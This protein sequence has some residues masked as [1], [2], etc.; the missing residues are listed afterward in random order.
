MTVCC[1]CNASRVPA[2]RPEDLAPIVYRL[3]EVTARTQCIFRPLLSVSRLIY[4]RPQ[5]VQRLLLYPRPRPRLIP[6]LLE[7][8]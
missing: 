5:H 4:S 3:E 1:R 6:V 7:T 2:P 8:Q